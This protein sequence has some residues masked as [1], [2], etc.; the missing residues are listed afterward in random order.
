MTKTTDADPAHPAFKPATRLVL[1]GRDPA[2]NHGFVNP[3]VHHVSTV[4]YPTAEDFLARRRPL[5][6]RASRHAHFGGS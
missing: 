3:P 6:L 1:G 4:L 5:P 2:A